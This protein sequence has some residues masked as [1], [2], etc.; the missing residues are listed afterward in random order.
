MNYWIVR[1]FSLRIVH[2]TM[3][4]WLVCLFSCQFYWWLAL[5]VKSLD[6]INYL[7]MHAPQSPLSSYSYCW[8]LS[9]AVNHS[10][11]ILVANRNSTL[12]RF[13]GSH[14][15]RGSQSWVYMQQLERSHFIKRIPHPL[16]LEKTAKNYIT[17]LIGWHRI[18]SKGGL[19]EVCLLQN[20][21]FFRIFLKGLLHPPPPLH[22]FGKIY[23][24][25]CPEI[26]SNAKQITILL[27]WW[28]FIMTA[29]PLFKW[30]G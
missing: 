26:H 10:N 17:K 2:R 16:G 18:L 8:R 11:P 25:C 21:W 19:R 9:P 20:R 4:L 7:L 5:K 29:L 3:V 23:C 15:K 24:N 22:F 30:P 27:L 14:K 12:I 28:Y 13:W 6:S 1:T